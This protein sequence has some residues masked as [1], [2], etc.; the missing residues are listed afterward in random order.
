MVA[1]NPFGPRVAGAALGP[2]ILPPATRQTV[3][4]ATFLVNL[5]SIFLFAAFSSLFEDTGAR[6]GVSAA[7]TRAVSIATTVSGR[8]GCGRNGSEG[9]RGGVDKRQKGQK[10]KGGGERLA[11]CHISH[12]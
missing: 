4:R 1:S 5:S 9:D 8:R 3:T 6:P 12:N 11:N 2:F 7:G 10:R